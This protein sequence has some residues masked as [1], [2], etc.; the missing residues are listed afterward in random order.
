MLRDAVARCTAS[1]AFRT[2]LRY[3]PAEAEGWFRAAFPEVADQASQLGADLGDSLALHFDAALGPGRSAVVIGSDAPL[4]PTAR[5]V[6]AHA[7]LERGVDLVLGPDDGGGYYLVG[8]AA[9]RPELFTRVAMSGGDVLE[10]TLS[11]ARGLGLAVEQLPPGRDV[12]VAADLTHLREGLAAAESG[13]E[14][15]HHTARV[16]AALQESCE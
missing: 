7:A 6:A 16:L 13:F 5:M 2:S 12:D 8:L 3:A 11:V 4:I 10:R 1:P 14:F 15:P 9:P